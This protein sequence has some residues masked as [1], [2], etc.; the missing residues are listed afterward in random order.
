MTTRAQVVT[1][2]LVL[3]AARAGAQ[4]TPEAELLW[5]HALVLLAQGDDGA[6][7]AL[8]EACEA[9]SLAA[10]LRG[11][12][13]AI[14]A[15]DLITAQEY[16]QAALEV[17][18][19]DRDIHLSLAR[20]MA[21]NGNYMWA[22]R[23][24]RALE[25]QGE[26]VAFE[27]GFC[28]HQLE[29]HEQAAERLVDAAAN[30]DDEAGISALYAAAS[31]ETLGRLEEARIM[32]ELASDAEEDPTVV[33]AGRALRDALRRSAGQPRV[34]ITGFATLSTLYDSNPVMSPDEPPSGTDG[35]RLRF[36]L[37]LLG[38]PLGG[39]WWAI[40]ARL[41][42]SRDQSFTELVRPYDFTSVRAG[43]HVR[44]NYEIGIPNEFRIAY[45]YGI[46][47]LDGGQGVEEDD[48]Y[49]YN[50]SHMGIFTYSVLPSPNFVTRL[51]LETGWVGFHRLARSGVPLKVVLG[52]S[53]FLFDGT[54][55]LYFEAGITAAWTEGEQYD[56]RGITMSLAAA[57]LTP[58]W[59]LEVILNWMYRW[60][61]YP[62]STG[63]GISFDYTRPNLRRRDSVTT[64]MLE[65]GRNFLDD[66]LRV[67]VRYR[68]S[69]NDSSIGAYDYLRHVVSLDITGGF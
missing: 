42:G 7:E 67:G 51:R 66:H 41:T 40:G 24:L 38:E 12:A 52:Q 30:D 4:E 47:M 23:E 54:L 58:L 2:L 5:N 20:V 9:E 46:G 61:H 26:E 49:V 53:A 14:E 29:Q 37:G 3:W 55:K 17:A 25:Q 22:I 15:E 10:C 27:L 62:Y 68:V 43:A 13:L 35:F 19:E 33:E 11:A 34:P 56:R 36:Q 59:D 48:F 21:A 45:R 63:V 18:P 39:S 50:E 57:Y 8:Y 28:L 64:L 1:V 6:D 65:V 32:A 16:L 44:F 60:S 31:L 69:D